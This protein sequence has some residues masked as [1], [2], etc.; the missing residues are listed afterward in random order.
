[1]VSVWRLI[2]T[3]YR[4]L[5]I[6]RRFISLALKQSAPT[7][8]FLMLGIYLVS[9]AM[10][11]LQTM[12][13]DIEPRASMICTPLTTAISYYS[14]RNFGCR[15]YLRNRNKRTRKKLSKIIDR[16]NF[17]EPV[18]RSVNTMGISHIR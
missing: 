12:L 18:L 11:H 2:R 5:R 1:M 3:W 14:M 17:D 8:Y 15:D 10:R 9:E 13:K 4:T 6:A 16:L 7:L